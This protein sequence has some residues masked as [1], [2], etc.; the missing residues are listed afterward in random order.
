MKTIR[1]VPTNNLGWAILLLEGRSYRTG[2]P[3]YEVARLADDGKYLVLYRTTNLDKARATAN[4][5]WRG[6]RDAHQAIHR[7]GKCQCHTHRP[8]LTAI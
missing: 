8:V 1:R 2:A 4:T 3:F 7:A 5:T 6:D